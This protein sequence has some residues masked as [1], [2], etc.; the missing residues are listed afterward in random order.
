[1]NQVGIPNQKGKRGRQRHGWQIQDLD[2]VLQRALAISRHGHGVLQGNAEAGVAGG[3]APPGAAQLACAPSSAGTSLGCGGGGGGGSSRQGASAGV[4]DDDDDDLMIVGVSQGSPQKPRKGRAKSGTARATSAWGSLGAR[5]QPQPQP[6]QNM[7]ATYVY[8]PPAAAS[9][10][11]THPSSQGQTISDAYSQRLESMAL[12]SLG[13]PGGWNSSELQG[14]SQSPGQAS[15]QGQGSQPASQQADYAVFNPGPK[16]RKYK[17]RGVPA[18]TP[19][20]PAPAAP[21]PGADKDNSVLI[22]ESDGEGGGQEVE[23]GGGGASASGGGAESGVDG[24]QVSKGDALFE[25]FLWYITTGDLGGGQCVFQVVGASNHTRRVL[26]KMTL[27]FG[28]DSRC[29]FKS[30]YENGLCISLCENLGKSKVTYLLTPTLMTYDAILLFNGELVNVNMPEVHFTNLTKSLSWIRDNHQE[31]RKK[32]SDKLDLKLG[33]H[34]YLCTACG[35]PLTYPVDTLLNHHGTMHSQWSV[36][37]HTPLIPTSNRPPPSPTASA[38]P[39]PS[40]SPKLRSVAPPPPPATASLAASHCDALPQA[41]GAQIAAAGAAEN[42]PLH[43]DGVEHEPTSTTASVVSTGMPPADLVGE[44]GAENRV[45]LNPGMEQAAPADTQAMPGTWCPVVESA[46]GSSGEAPLPRP[47]VAYRDDMS[48]GY[49][50]GW[51]IVDPALAQ[52]MTHAP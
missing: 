12:A 3:S 16:R 6:Q 22:V 51:D 30:A 17:K 33:K 11:S 15:S 19:Q 34:N 21:V 10:Q 20:A 37:A 23:S 50:G 26:A 49:Q 39:S 43:R 9:Q 8:V 40:P 42:C 48:D 2:G 24:G 45:E 5:P 31:Y 18:A 7:K 25:H 28:S 4:D 14:Y 35:R 52:L 38:S 13:S 47:Q 44:D 1:M 32:A 41:D 27:P 36:P 29:N 46:V